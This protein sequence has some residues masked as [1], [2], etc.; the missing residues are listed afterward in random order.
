MILESIPMRT[1]MPASNTFDVVEDFE[2]YGVKVANDRRDCFPTK[3][4]NAVALVPRS[5]EK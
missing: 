1:F 3:G 2:R 4:Y 5:N